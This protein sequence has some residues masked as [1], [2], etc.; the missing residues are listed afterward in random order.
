MYTIIN[1]VKPL[2]GPLKTK[3]CCRDYGQPMLPQLTTASFVITDCVAESEQLLTGGFH[4][5]VVL[6]KVVK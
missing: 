1:G 2:G 6:G 3:D 5:H 4:T